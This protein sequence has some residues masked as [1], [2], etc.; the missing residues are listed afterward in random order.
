M[1]GS[2]EEFLGR[3]V[4]FHGLAAWSARLADQT[5]ASHCYSDWFAAK[6][7]EQTLGRLVLAAGS[8]GNHRIRPLQL[9]WVFEHARI[10]LGLR[11]DGACLALFVENRPD[12]P[13]AAAE[14]VLDEFA[15]LPA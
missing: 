6:Q 15:R 1:K 2:L 11:R 14:G 10:H 4:P 8:L 13:R 3:R 12:L 7:A 5:M 9:C